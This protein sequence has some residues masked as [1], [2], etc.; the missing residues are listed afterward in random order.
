MLAHTDPLTQVVN[1]R[2]LFGRL[3]AELERARRY[4]SVMSV[5]MLDIDHFKD[6]NDT[7]GHL[8]GDD[9][10]REVAGLLQTTVRSVDVVARY[11]GEE[12]VVV[13]PETPLAGAVTF[14]ERIRV[15]I[16]S[17]PFCPA[18]GPLSITVSVGVAAFPAEGVE[19]IENL[20][21]RADD[22]LYRAKAEGRNAVAV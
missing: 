12:F 8:I 10:L 7:H 11:G 4:N 6:I 9:V 17:H 13:L 20:F 3:G 21:A 15:L 5:L 22:A 19:T 18:Q 14:A 1:R 16:E 2:A